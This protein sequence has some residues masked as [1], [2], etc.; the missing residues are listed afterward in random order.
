MSASG[1]Y[2]LLTK[3]TTSSPHVSNNFGVTWTAVSSGLVGSGGIGKMS[4]DGKYMYIFGSA[5]KRST[6]FGVS[7]SNILTGIGGLTEGGIV[8]SSGRMVATAVSGL[9]GLRVS[10]DYGASFVSVT[11]TLPTIDT[12]I[13]IACSYDGMYSTIIFYGSQAVY[14]SSQFITNWTA[15]TILSRSLIPTVPNTA[16][17]GNAM[18]I[19]G[20]FN[21]ATHQ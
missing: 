14:R 8:S 6:D 19:T 7:F 20:Q 17:Y 12:S 13:R 3:N 4:A 18:S 10:S 16:P 1:R 21:I 15:G 9:V 5:A 11:S 2:I